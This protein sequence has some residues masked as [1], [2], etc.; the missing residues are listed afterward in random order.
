MIRRNNQPLSQ[1][2]G[3]FYVPFTK[4]ATQCNKHISVNLRAHLYKISQIILITPIN[5]FQLLFTC[6]NMRKYTRDKK[7]IN[8]FGR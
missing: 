8:F 5:L 6:N 7:I 2:K 3:I 1:E 4:D